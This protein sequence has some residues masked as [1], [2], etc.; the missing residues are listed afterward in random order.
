MATQP[1][2]SDV[3]ESITSDVKTIVK[4]EIEL[5]KAEMVPQVKSVGVGAG[6]FGAAGYLG[7]QAATLI[8]VALGFLISQFFLGLMAPGFAYASGFN[9]CI[10]FVQ[11][12]AER[13]QLA[14]D[15]IKFLNE[16]AVRQERF[17][18][19]NRYAPFTCIDMALGT[20]KAHPGFQIPRLLPIGVLILPNKARIGFRRQ[21]ILYRTIFWHGRQMQ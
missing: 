3:I 15:G 12:P 16:R 14:I 17:V 7:L 4:G 6:L 21:I 2:L 20:I 18:N 19:E 9:R 13:G 1:A 5:A 11:F 10:F 8:F